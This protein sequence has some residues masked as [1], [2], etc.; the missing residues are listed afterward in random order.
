[1]HFTPKHLHFKI[2]PAKKVKGIFC[3][4]YGC[5]N[6]PGPKKGGLCSKHYNRHRRI[7]DPV[8]DRYFNF[9][10]NALRRGKG[11]FI[12]LKEFRDFCN[13]TGYIIKK[14]M[15]GRN[16]TI[17]RIKNKLPYTI[18]NIQLL[19]FDKNLDKYINEDRFEEDL[20]F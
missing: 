3:C 8:Y 18:D 12:T 6:K 9:K 15:R 20:P 13:E 14:G 17:D 11:F 10:H 1:M 5:S 16:C 7:I 2:S 19:R 4:A